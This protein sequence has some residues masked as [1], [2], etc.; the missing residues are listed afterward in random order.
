MVIIITNQLFK[1]MTPINIMNNLL[2]IKEDIET[3]NKVR[4]LEILKIFMNRQVN[5]SENKNGVFINLSMLSPEMILILTNKI[6]YYKQQ[7]VS[8]IE[9]EN[10]KQEFHDN[11]FEKKNEQKHHKDN[12]Q[13]AI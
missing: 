5:I 4:Q 13:Y 11:F 3:L 6:L 10:I 12:V 8:L 9:I 1:N 7:D 2:R